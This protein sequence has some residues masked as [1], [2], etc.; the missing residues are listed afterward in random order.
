V[1]IV[2]NMQGIGNPYETCNDIPP[3]QP[4]LRLSQI[5]VP[6]CTTHLNRI[7]V[8]HVLAHLADSISGW[9]IVNC[10]V[11]AAVEA[12]A[13]VETCRRRVTG[14]DGT[15]ERVGD[16]CVYGVLIAVDVDLKD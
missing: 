2:G 9:R 1:L 15:K 5:C 10:D 3:Y 14:D 13:C 4:R 6:V 7:H 11:V 8:H 12:F 16:V